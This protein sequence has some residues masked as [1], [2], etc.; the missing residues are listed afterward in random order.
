MKKQNEVKTVRKGRYGFNAESLA[1]M[2]LTEAYK[3][4]KNVN[5]ATVKEAHSEAVK[6]MKK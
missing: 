3:A 1:A 4:F 2:S 6:L 5:Q